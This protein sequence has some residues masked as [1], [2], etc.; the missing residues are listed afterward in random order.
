M[1][2]PK[3][4]HTLIVRL[5]G[6]DERAWADFVAAYEPF[7]RQLA[8]RHGVP[9]S[10]VSDVVQQVLL[11]IAKSVDGWTDDGKGG[12]F[13]RWIATVARNVAIKF[14]TR[15]RKHKGV[16]GGTDLV[17]LLQQ[18]PAP[19]D[20]EQLRKYEH[21]LIVWAAEQVRNEFVATSWAA[22]WAT[23]VEGRDV[24][25]VATELGLSR[26]AIY[27]SRGRIMTRIRTK[28]GEVLEE[29]DR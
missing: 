2:H 12:S 19:P 25:E 6:D 17:D 15:E 26:G 28:V 20:R 4:R 16:A 11:A 7:L 9:Q 22:F 1:S 5:K 13:R 27:M 10:H 8:I 23:T 14:M 21:E 24:T 18:I 3:T 29:D